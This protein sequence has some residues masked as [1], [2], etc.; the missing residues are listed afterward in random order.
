M[1]NRDPYPAPPLSA[2][3]SAQM[4]RMPRK[5]S[6][7]ELQLR[8]AMHRLGL[9]FRTQAPL[10]GRPDI[11]LTR[12]KIA[13]FV[14]GCFWH[15]CPEHATAPKNNAEWWDAKLS[16]NVIR[17]R[18]KDEAIRSLGWTP[19]HVWEH[20]NPD[21]AAHRIRDLWRA[22]IPAR[23]ESQL[24]ELSAILETHAAAPASRNQEEC[25]RVQ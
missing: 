12:A 8:R 15:R 18:E 14:D 2:T 20:E 10:P 21:E 17:D 5:E 25:H 7:P 19:V 13:I 24:S 9:R 11:V 23:A 1:A 22:A 4:R 6:G 16:R 3:V